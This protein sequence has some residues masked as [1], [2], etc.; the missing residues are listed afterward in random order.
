[1]CTLY[2][3]A[4]EFFEIFGNYDLF[5]MYSIELHVQ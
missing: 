3:N 2:N 5:M 4:P 1:M